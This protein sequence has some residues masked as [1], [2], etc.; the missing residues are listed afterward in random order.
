MKKIIVAAALVA[1]ALVGSVFVLPLALSSDTLRTALA[2]Q[3]SA[4]SGAEIALNGPIH[5][6]VLPDFGVVVEDL[7]YAAG[8]GTVV[9]TAARSVASVELMSLFSSQVRITGIELR[10][11]RII[12]GDSIAAEPVVAAEPTA[13]RDEDVFEVI[14][15]YLERLSIDR[16]VVTDGEVARAS[17]GAIEPLASG[18][19]LH[20]SVPGISEP[21]ALAIS[22]LLNGKKMELAAKIGSLRDLLAREPAEFSLETTMEQPLHPILVDLRASGSIQLADDGSYRIT[23]GAIDS[24]GQT[25]RL[26]ASYTPGQRPFVM[27]RVAAGTLDYSDFQ[28]DAPNPSDE[29]GEEA[30]STGGAPDL[31]LLRIIDADIELRAVA[32]QAGDAIARN[33]VIGTTLQN[34]QLTTSVRSEQIAGGSLTAS[35]SMDVNAETPQSS[36]ALNLASIDIERLMALVGQA[37]PATGRLSSQLQYAFRGADAEAIRDSLNLRGAVSIAEGRIAVPQLEDVVG[38]GAGVVAGLNATAQ[39]EDVLQPLSLSGTAQWNGEAINFTTALTLSDLLWGQAGA[40]TV[41]VKAQPANARF[42]GT[43]SPDGAASGKVDITAASLSRALTWLGQDTG[44]SLGRFAFSGGVSA[45]STALAVTDATIDLDDIHAKGSVSVVTTGKP[46]ITATLAVDT[47]DFGELTGGSGSGPASAGPAAIDLSMLRLF[48]ADIRFSANQ[49][50]YGAV[51]A[52]PATATLS[53]ANGVA[54]LA[55]PQAGFYDGTVTANVTANGAGDVPTVELIAGMDGVQALP[56]LTAAAGFDRLEGRLKASVQVTGAGANTEAFAR[57]LNGPVNVVFSDGAIRGIDVAGLVRNVQSLIG[58]GYTQDTEAKT[59]FTELSVVVNIANGIGR[60]E[61]IRLLGPFVRMSGQGSI[62]LTAQTIDM[63]LDPRVVGSLDGQGGAF[64]V[65]GLGMPIIVT[66]ALSSPSIYPDISGILADPNRALQALSQLG[67]GVGELASG[68]S[69]AFG[70]LGDS[71][72]GGS[73]AAVVTD[74]IGRLSGNEP[75]SAADAAPVGEGALLNSVL[76]GIFGQ[77]AS[78]P[79]NSPLEQQPMPPVETGPPV[80]APAAAVLLPRPDP[81]GA[82][83]AP[84][85]A[86][87]PEAG[88]PLTDSLVEAIVPQFVPD[89]EAETTDLI[90]NLIQGIGR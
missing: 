64:D 1:I 4:V 29:T 39:I 37:A 18:I 27:A 58:A 52:G 43:I 90:K 80:I 10:S 87:E 15:G 34:G 55:V 50:G 56:L 74:L 23:D 14:A 82:P 59:E 22:G 65:S 13:A 73:G 66:G 69:G 40:V 89:A 28:P 44:A 60:A 47:L 79:T 49:L 85:P 33:V 24:L 25:M 68:A 32:L 12:L 11:P 86:P 19:D 54:K 31:S 81:R 7:A 41:D 57:S 53:V 8:D 84:P 9:V 77:P 78:G 3:L 21:A 45:G 46:T 51:K 67:G 42:S 63:R 2:R 20:L 75:D 71:L 35:L 5:F 72:G 76:G 6:S 48:D 70:A 36:G 83:L 26:D 38:R 62:D 88:V 17:A 61:D 30:S 16:V